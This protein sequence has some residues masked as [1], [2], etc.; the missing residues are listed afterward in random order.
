MKLKPNLSETKGL[1]S[2]VAMRVAGA[3]SLAVV[4]AFGGSAYA[5]EAAVDD[6]APSLV[7]SKPMKP[8]TRTVEEMEADE[9]AHPQAAA[10]AGEIPFRPT[11]DASDYEFEKGAA[12]AASKSARPQPSSASLV[13]AT[14]KNVNC[15]G[16][17]QAGLVP[18]DTHGAIGHTHYVQIVNSAIRG[19][20][21]AGINGD[22]N[23]ACGPPVLNTSLAAF[24]G[25]FAQTLFDPRVVYDHHYR[26]WIVTAEAFPESAT[27]QRHFVA[28]SKTANAAGAY[29]IYNLDVNFFNNTEFF[30]YP[31]LG[32]DADAVII[33]ANIFNP[34]YVGSRVIS[35]S[36]SRIYNG[37][38]VPFC[39]FFGG[40]LNNGT[41]A[42]PIVRDL[43]PET[44]LASAAPADSKIRVTKW[45]NFGHVCPTFVATTD[46]PV[47]AYTVPA[48]AP[49][50]GTA[51]TLDV[52]DSRFVN[53]ST[54]IGNLLYNVHAIA[55]GPAAVR[56]YILNVPA[57][58][59]SSS[60]FFSSAISSDF[61][62]SIAVNDVLNEYIT[63]SR[64]DTATFP[65]VRFAGKQSADAGFGLGTAFT[66]PTFLSGN[67]GR[68]GD[69]S[70]ITI[71]PTSTNTAWGVNEKANLNHTWGSRI[72]KIGI[73]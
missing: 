46:I 8:V 43:G 19:Y 9:A 28:V 67:G 72:F 13:P 21:R 23:I 45:K 6:G 36:K 2:E 14:L 71:D 3:V 58:T 34:G 11:M 27:V 1:G 50:P 10:P 33:T 31:Q 30:D 66:S 17:S 68:W 54:Q 64:S 59:A 29:F 60:T 51:E 7:T 53:A 39:F 42:P 63:F 20:T 56:R 37:L 48:D 69:Y 26:R 40:P 24:F 35:L 61:N 15:D 73:P 47:A 41:I 49:Q 18:P 70:A 38:G 62:A 55:F 22:V 4:L 65:Q 52:L 12:A 32:F 5:E 57:G 25:Y 16:L 44:W